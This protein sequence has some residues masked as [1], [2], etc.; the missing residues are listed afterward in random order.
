MVKE[1]RKELTF[2]L[3]IFAFIG[4]NLFLGIHFFHQ[5]EDFRLKNGPIS[6]E[7]KEPIDALLL[8]LVM[9]QIDGIKA[10]PEI[11]KLKPHVPVIML[12]GH[13]TIETAVKSLKLGAH[14]FLEKT[15]STNRILVTLENAI[16]R[17][18]L[19]QEKRRLL[20]TVQEEHPMIG[21]S[22]A[23]KKVLHMIGKMAPIDSPVLI[24][25]E[26]G[27]GKE[28]VARALHFNSQ[29]AGKPF[30][31]VNASAISEGVMESELFGHEKGAFTDAKTSR[32]G[33]F[34]QAHTGTLFLDEISEMPLKLQ[35]KLLRA[36]ESQ[37]IQR[38]GGNTREKLDV[39]IIAAS[40]QDL[41]KAVKEGRFRRD[42]YH[43]IEV[44]TIDVPPLR[45]RKVDIPLLVDYFVQK[46]NRRTKIPVIPFHAHAMELLMKYHWPG[47]IRE[48]RNVVEK[49][50]V[51]SDSNEILPKDIRPHLEPDR[52]VKESLHLP[53]TPMTV[54]MKKPLYL[55]VFQLVMADLM[56]HGLIIFQL[57]T[58]WR[59]P[60]QY[61][62]LIKNHQKLFPMRAGVYF[63]FSEDI[64]HGAVTFMMIRGPTIIKPIYGQ[65]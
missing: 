32:A 37:E 47:N 30:V 61:I 40:N 8:D 64:P 3:I 41:A 25:G 36:I 18:E 54:C 19:E 23:I 44:L 51:L 26:N 63:F 21:D 57:I 20:R 2:I 29:R 50:R 59:W 28:L 24:T 5:L 12:S 49:A 42:L 65:I 53:G 62:L 22:D 15:V 35:P 45:E 6:M 4:V 17:S 16:R 7:V 52:E 11:K 58:G 9:P 55:A 48:L 14:D 13:G 27:T 56:T 31:P 46:H 38:V 39:R 1:L 34:E 33:L 43:R 10:L 60:Q